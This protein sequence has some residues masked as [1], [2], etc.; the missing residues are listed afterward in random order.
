MSNTL[1]AAR[2]FRQARGE[3]IATVPEVSLSRLYALRGGYLLIAA[4]LGVYVWPGI[5]HHQKPWELMQG[6][7]FCVLAAVSILAA[8][9]LRYPLRM[10]PLLFFEMAWKSIWLAIVAL[11]LWSAGRMDAG[12]AATAFACLMAVVFPFVIPWRYVWASYVVQPGDRWR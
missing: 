3:R 11:P 4:G 7:V 8:I 9:G 6:V 10:L 1:L 5:L 2:A 12:T